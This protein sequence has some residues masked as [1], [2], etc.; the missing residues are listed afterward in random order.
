MNSD[1]LL[2]LGVIVG[3]MAFPALVS[4][5]SGGRSVKFSIGLLVA[6]GVLIVAASVTHPGGYAVSDVPN[7]F[8]R[9]IANLIN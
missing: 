7:V 8:L 6:G 3:T 2:F 1:F 4:A 5:F 9:V